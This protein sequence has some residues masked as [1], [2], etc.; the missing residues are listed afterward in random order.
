[1][2][3]KPNVTDIDLRRDGKQM[4]LVYTVKEMMYGFGDSIRPHPKSVSI[5]EQYVKDYIVTMVNLNTK[6]TNLL[7]DNAE[8]TPDKKIDEEIFLFTIRK[9]K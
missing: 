6:Q 1:M 4:N 5:L 2:T 8:L 9:D 7:I 3:L